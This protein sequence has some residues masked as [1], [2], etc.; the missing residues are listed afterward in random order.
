LAATAVE[1]VAAGP[2]AIVGC[3]AALDELVGRLADRGYPLHDAVR[4]C[5]DLD[6][7][8]AQFAECGI[9]V[10]PALTTLW[11]EVGTICLVDLGRCRHVGYWDEI[12]QQA[13]TAA[14]GEGRAGDRAPC[15]DGVVVDGPC[16]DG[17]I[18]YVIEM[19]EEAEDEDLPRGIEL[20]PDELHKDNISG[21]GPYELL[22]PGASDDPWLAAISGFRWPARRPH[23]APPDPP[24]LVSYLRTA[25]LECGGFP[26]LHGHPAYAP[27][28][29]ELT[30]GL[31][32]F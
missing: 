12:L 25:I 21:S 18:E 19:L 15:C 31:P 20:G 16:D 27:I 11:R 32:I 17:W 23:S 29:A 4:A 6:E 22:L 14:A 7:A 9:E 5:P 13:T 2:P 30:A 26:G 1:R 10:P 3:A 8:L 24:D 28:L